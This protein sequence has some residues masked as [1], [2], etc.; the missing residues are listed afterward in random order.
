MLVDSFQKTFSFHQQ[1]KS[2]KPLLPASSFSELQWL[3][4]KSLLLAH[5]EKL[6]CW[7]LN[8]NALSLDKIP[9]RPTS[10]PEHFPT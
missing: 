10:D 1:P 9:P 2:S 4:A 8:G 7:E 3:A 5:G 6:G